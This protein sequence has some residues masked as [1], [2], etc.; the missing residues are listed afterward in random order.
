M[1]SIENVM[2]QSQHLKLLYVE[3]NPVVV[4]STL[5]ILEEFFTH[6]IVAVDGVDGLEK[7]EENDID[8]IITDISMPNMNG[9]E[10]IE[11]IRESDS[12]I[13]ITILSAYSEAEYF[14]RG[15]ELGV[16]GYLL[17]PFDM[18]Q[19]LAIL[20]N[21]IKSIQLRQEIKKLNERMDLALEG[22]ETSILDWDFTDN[23]F[24]ISS[25]W[26]EMLGYSDDE[27]PNSI[28]TWKEK[29][30]RDDRKRV[31]SSLRKHLAEQIQYYENR[32]RLQ[33]KDGHW[34]W[35]LGRAQ[36]LYDKEG[37]AV[38]MI[39]TH[40]DITAEKEAEVAASE[41][42]KYLQSIIDGV[43]DPIMVIKED[44][45]IDL[46]NSTIRKK[47]KNVN[48]EDPEYPK[49]Y[50]VSHNRST[51]C[52]GTDHPCPLKDV[53]DTKEH[54]VVI[55]DHYNA[56]GEKRYV[57]ISASP[58]FD[59]AHNCIGI[60]ESG[61]D[62]TE[63]I[64]TQDAL[65]EQKNILQYQAHHDTLTG[66]PNRVL[67]N[68]RLEQGIERAKRSNRCLALFFLDLDHFKEINDSLGHAVGD[69]VLKVVTKRLTEIIRKEDTLARLGGDEFTFIIEGLEQS[70]DASLLAE[71]ILKVLKE[72]IIVK[73]NTL[74]VSSSIGISL[75]PQDGKNAQDLLKYSDAAM[76]KAK[77]EGRNNFQ[78]YNAE[79][80]RAAL[81][82]VVMEASLREALKNEDFTVYY[83]P[84]VNAESNKLIGMEA[85]VRWQHP[86]K[87]LVSPAKFIHLA[88]S[89]G[90]IIELDR[91]VMKTAMTQMTKWYTDGLNPGVLALNLSLRQLQKQDFISTLKNTMQETGCKP[92]W[93]EFEVTEGQIMSSPEEII[94]VLNKI[95][96][97]GIALSVDDYGTGYSSLSYLK[98]LP[99]NKLK[100]DR[101]F[102][103]KLPADEDNATITRSVIALAQ[104][105]N[106]N[107][108]AEGVETKEQKEFLLESGCEDIQGYLYGKPMPKEEMEVLLNE[109]LDLTTIGI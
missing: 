20:T 59:H 24:Y 2:E 68:D 63:H 50:E 53:I 40:T 52:D 16:D 6:I 37:K 96:A 81:D 15:I 99:I 97:L 75:Y 48:I 87:G 14:I 7:L 22:S 89:T 92:E 35:I 45:T 17:K 12:D 79:M 18:E 8:L 104:S 107:V 95:H 56:K 66:L 67:F 61:R 38:R 101:S 42:H 73:E 10:M 41:Q 25:C 4:E 88:E 100:I 109:G 31:F 43:N 60:I 105:L 9:F 64:E 44:Y 98:R 27:L 102:V 28:L 108:I 30:H 39:G 26:K 78:F 62:V 85:L 55:H 32:H 34:I 94:V 19:F 29:V 103:Q 11:K 106:L 21:V 69:K 33:H 84:Q 83:Q 90:I 93:I 47:L 86:M 72:P 3:D 77:E 70:Q 80:T 23:S 1:N 91:F 58:L 76:Y 54:M 5:M 13:S 51:P 71:K 49:C 57:E 65:E 74:Y 46:M 82:R 36:I